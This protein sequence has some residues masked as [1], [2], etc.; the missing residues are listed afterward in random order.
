TLAERTSARQSV[1]DETRGSYCRSRRTKRFFL[2]VTTP[3]SRLHIPTDALSHT[4]RVHSP[5]ISI[6]GHIHLGRREFLQLGALG[7]GLTGKAAATPVAAA[8]KNAVRS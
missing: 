3:R 4:P 7:L 5:M 8:P 6:G 2:K 1:R